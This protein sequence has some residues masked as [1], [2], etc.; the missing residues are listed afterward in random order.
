MGGVNGRFAAKT[1]IRSTVAPQNR[2]WKPKAFIFTAFSAVKNEG[3]TR[4][5]LPRSGGANR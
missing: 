2:D 4:F 5:T 3:R 1:G